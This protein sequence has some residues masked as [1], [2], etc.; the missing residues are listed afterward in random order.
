MHIL[1][2]RG[3]GVFSAQLSSWFMVALAIF[4][5]C[6]APFFAHAQNVSTFPDD[7]GPAGLVPCG[8]FGE[9]SCDVCQVENLARD[10]LK[11]VIYAAIFLATLMIAY[12]GFKMITAQGDSGALTAAKEMLSMVVLGL[13]LV[14]G[15]WLIVD[16][17]MRVFFQGGSSWNT[18]GKC[19]AQPGPSITGSTG[20]TGTGGVQVGTPTSGTL[21]HN[22]ALQKL[23]TAGINVTSTAGAAG[24]K[25][26]CPSM[27]GCT[28]LNGIRRDTLDQ[29]L[30]VKEKC[31]SCTVTIVG[32][33]EPHAPGAVSHQTG[34]KV[35]IQANSTVDNFFTSTLV[36]NGSREGSN[37]GPRYNDSCGNEYVRESSHWDVTVNKGVCR[38]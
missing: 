7:R 25:E 23:Q 5:F 16:T 32:A 2:A 3:H 9:K 13:V 27:E 37:G 33:T 1:S 38:F 11:L 24:V 35:D 34:Y 15:A 18:F 14:L 30:Y 6:S 29:S 19:E 26:N 36:R 8:D 10:A 31:P 28:T 22:D 4:L 17:L 21:V 20:T 12:A